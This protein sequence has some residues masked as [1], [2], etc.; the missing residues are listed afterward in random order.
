MMCRAPLVL[1]LTLA[2][3][4]SESQAGARRSCDRTCK[5]FARQCTVTTPKAGRCKRLL[6]RLDKCRRRFADVP[7]AATRTTTSSTTTTTIPGSGVLITVDEARAAT[8]TLPL[9]GG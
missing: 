6:H 5:R 7:C 8:Q 4:V 3:S 2:L 1:I 9:Q